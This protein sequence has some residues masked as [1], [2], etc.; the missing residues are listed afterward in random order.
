MIGVRYPT[1]VSVPLAGT[2]PCATFTY[3]GAL[4]KVI[5]PNAHSDN[6][7]TSYYL[8]GP[9]L[10]RVLP[11]GRRHGAGRWRR[12]EPLQHAAPFSIHHACFHAAVC[13][14]VRQPRPGSRQPVCCCLCRPPG[15]HCQVAHTCCSPCCALPML[16]LPTL[17]TAHANCNAACRCASMSLTRCGRRTGW[18]STRCAFCMQIVI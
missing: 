8:Q 5:C 18:P 14:A 10:A 11:R 3:A 4:H 15:M 7:V 12:G 1:A 13:L 9:R 6:A 17:C 16:P 2:P